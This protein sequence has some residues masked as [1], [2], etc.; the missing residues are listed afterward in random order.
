[1]QYVAKGPLQTRPTRRSP[2]KAT[3]LTEPSRQSVPMA[4][5]QSCPT[6]KSQPA[7]ERSL[8]LINVSVT[9][10]RLSSVWTWLFGALFA[11]FDLPPDKQAISEPSRTWV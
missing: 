5:L 1:M 4:D 3:I 10:G 11:V 6:A 8:I 7:A 9:T 2:I